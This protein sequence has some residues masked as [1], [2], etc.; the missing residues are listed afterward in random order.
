MPTT[1]S[2]RIKGAALAL[3]LGGEDY[4]V[5]VTSVS[6]ENEEAAA[7]VTTFEDAS[8]GGARQFY[9]TGT[10]IQSTASTSFWNY[11]WENTGDI[12]E[13]YYAP[14]GNNTATADEPHFH[15]NVKIPS[16]PFVGGEAG[17]NNEF[18]FDFRMDCQEEPEKLTSG[19]IVTP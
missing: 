15:R 7:G 14:H 6:L 9:I 2:T 1:G 16:K 19:S 17:A 10:A 5:D 13:Y 3:N 12:V 8:L 11:I 4:W 18:T